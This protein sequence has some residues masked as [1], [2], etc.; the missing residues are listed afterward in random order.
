[1]LF[2][3]IYA[4]LQ[5]ISSQDWETF[6]Y[7]ILSRP[8][9]FQ[10]L[11]NDVS[12]CSQLH[13]MTLLHAAVRYGSPLD[14]I[15]DMIRLCPDMPA[16]KD[17]LGRT[18]L[19]VAAGSKASASLLKILAHACPAACVVQDEEGKTPLHFHR[20]TDHCSQH[21]MIRLSD[22][23]TGTLAHVSSYLASPSCVLLFAVAINHRDVDSSTDITGSPWDA[24]DFGDIEK[25]LAAKLTDDDINNAVLTYIDAV[26]NIKKLRLT[27]CINITGVGLE[28]RCEVQ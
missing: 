24:L 23:P 15:V 27:N 12:S 13:G 2:N 4:I 25:E 19:H 17:C 14:V 16:T 21:T 3:S 20:N 6:R 11:A 9:L 1:M 22:L 28:P 8:A 26:N 5:L 18:P 7:A 10:N